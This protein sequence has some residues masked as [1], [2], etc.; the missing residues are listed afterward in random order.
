MGQE[1][2]TNQNQEDLLGLGLMNTIKISKGSSLLKNRD[3]SGLK[4]SCSC[5]YGGRRGW[6]FCWLEMRSV[7]S[8]NWLEA[9]DNPI[10]VDHAAPWGQK[11]SNEPYIQSHFRQG[12]LV[13]GSLS[14]TF[15]S[16]SSSSSPPDQNHCCHCH[17]HLLP[18]CCSLL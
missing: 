6:G 16:P 2:N 8:G 15:F 17:Y 1:R 4:K 7:M 5:G 13:M 12:S 10:G 14:G 18:L 9:L 3:P 11:G